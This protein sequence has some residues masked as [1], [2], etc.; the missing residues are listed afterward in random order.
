MSKNRPKPVVLVVLDGWGVAP[1]GDG[2]AISQAKTPVM[3]KLITTYPAMTLGAAS[4]EVGLNF[5]E[6]GNS[7]VGHLT[8][9]AGRVLY[10]NLP[11]ISRAITDKSFFSNETLR[12]VM[13][14]A[15][16]K[17]SKL[18]LI[19]LTS[20]GGVHGHI[21]HLLALLEMAKKEKVKRV[22]IHAILDGRDTLPSVADSYIKTVQE[23]IDK[24][25]LGAMASLSGR[26]YA[27]D[28]DNR[29]DRTEQA[30]RAMAEG[31]SAEMFDDPREAIKQSY[32]KKVLD[33][34]FLPTVIT[35]HGAP[36]ATIDDGDA[37]IFFNFRSDRARQLTKAFVLPDFDKFKRQYL[38]NLFF[39]TMME[40]EKD[41]PVEVAFPPHIVDEPLA[42]VIAAAGL[43][44]LHIAETE[45]YAHVTFFFNGLKDVK[46]K[47][48]DQVVVPSPPVASYDKAPEMSAGKITERALKEIKADTYD[49]ILINFAN[50]DMVAHTAKIK[51]T[52]KGMEFVDH[53][54][55]QIIDLVL[56]KDGV[57]FVT[58]DHGNAEEM[59]NLQTGEALKDH[60]TNP[61]PFIAVGKVWEGQTGNLPEGVGPDLSLVPPGGILSDVAPTV[62][63][64]LNIKAPKEMTGAP[65]I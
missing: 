58:A 7:E 40:Y 38:P 9:G 43:K 1:P 21:D 51:P 32:K 55:G 48:E 25:N 20:D 35:E 19:G 34:E 11:R 29:W 63:Q 23:K 28:R 57:V 47:G 44:Q 24:L 39:V 37:V 61:V 4:A 2:N 22:Y 42:A 8:I 62:L 15:K 45:K 33:E 30:Y 13:K 6:I 56:A 31:Q 49:F 64:A 36:V 41:L 46:Y 12:K 10:E 5:G 53:C 14:H 59:I 50:A 60:S 18:H 52:I 65:L 54:L 27:M 3:N 17:E 26:Y 16:D